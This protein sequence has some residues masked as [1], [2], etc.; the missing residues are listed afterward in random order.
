[1]LTC[2]YISFEE[3]SAMLTWFSHVD[4]PQNC[5]PHAWH[6]SLVFGLHIDAVGRLWELLEAKENKTSDWS[7]SCTYRESKKGSGT[8]IPRSLYGIDLFF[9]LAFRLNSLYWRRSTSVR[10]LKLFCVQSDVES[11]WIMNG[12]FCFDVRILNRKCIADWWVIRIIFNADFEFITVYK[13]MFYNFHIVLNNL[14]FFCIRA[15][16]E[17]RLHFAVLNFAWEDASNGIETYSIL[18]SLNVTVTGSGSLYEHNCSFVLP[19]I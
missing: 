12:G 18:C 15:R 7:Q 8:Y 17:S 5:N 19:D 14:D 10:D 13:V 11:V 2:L 16:A 3:N 1:M 4:F 9:P 6:V